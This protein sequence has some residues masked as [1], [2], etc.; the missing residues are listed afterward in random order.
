[1]MLLRLALRSLWSYRHKTLLVGTLLAAVTALVV[2]SQGLI[3]AMSQS[4]EGSLT[5]TVIGH[6][7]LVNRS[8]TRTGFYDLPDEPI[9]DFERVQRA[10]GELDNVR[11]IVPMGFYYAYQSLGSRLEQSLAALRAAVTAGD[12]KEMAVLT[13]QVRSLLQADLSEK[14]AAVDIA[15]VRRDHPEYVRAQELLAVAREER[16]WQDFETDPLGKLEI[17]ENNVGAVT[18]EQLMWLIYMATDFTQ[19]R[20]VFQ[21]LEIVDGTGIPPGERGFLFNKKVYDDELKDP[22]ARRLDQLKEAFDRGERLERCRDCRFWIARNV[23]SAAELVSKVKRG[24]EDLVLKRLR[25]HLGQPQGDAVALMRAFLEMDSRTFARRYAFFTHELAPHLALYDVPIGGRIVL[26][27]VAPRSGYVR[28]VPVKVY[29]TF[30]YRGLD[31]T[32]YGTLVNITDLATFGELFGY[33][34]ESQRREQAA[35]RR[36]AGV[37]DLSQ[38]D[39]EANLGGVGLFEEA[40]QQ[41]E[42]PSGPGRLEAPPSAQ[43]QVLDAGRERQNRPGKAAASAGSPVFMAAV[44]LADARRLDQTLQQVRALISR[45]GLKVRAVSWREVQTYVGELVSALQ[46][47]LVVS[48]LAVF[49]VSLIMVNHTVLVA[50]MA[51]EREIGTLR[52]IGAGR[53]FVAA[54]VLAETV[55][56]AL[57]ATAVGAALGLTLVWLLNR[58]GIAPQ[59]KLTDMLFGGQALRPLLDLSFAVKAAV[60]LALAAVVA[61]LYPLRVASRISPREAMDKG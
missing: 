4:L 51:R 31:R 61:V 52:A 30:R 44:V 37:K 35:L 5:D 40:R 24:A 23:A 43:R 28:R 27:G 17:L 18:L 13:K 33:L 11:A 6:I 8:V 38:A 41:V 54:T 20:Q 36:S 46:M 45:E 12:K 15:R 19:Y 25:T 48:L 56:L 22:T 1:M 55:L 58:L 57:A 14:D 50:T 10:I 29:G 9:A 42:P 49:V 21:R 34:D 26:T 7:R 32:T 47:T 53:G 16:F 59:G 39:L 3:A 60:G 2:V